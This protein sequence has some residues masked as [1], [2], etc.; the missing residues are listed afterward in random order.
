[1]ISEKQI[2]SGSASLSGSLDLIFGFQKSLLHAP[3]KRALGQR[4]RKSSL[5]AFLGVL[6]ALAANKNGTLRSFGLCG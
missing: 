5:R 2:S 6:G 3:A 1:M 4:S